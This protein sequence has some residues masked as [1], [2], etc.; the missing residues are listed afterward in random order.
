MVTSRDPEAAPHAEKPVLRRHSA[1]SPSDFA[2]V[3]SFFL[4]SRLYQRY[5]RIISDIASLPGAT[6]DD[7]FG[8]FVCQLWTMDPVLIG[9][10]ARWFGVREE[11]VARCRDRALEQWDA[12]EGVWDTDAHSQLI[13]T[14]EQVTPNPRAPVSNFTRMA[15]QCRYDI[16]VPAF[17]DGSG[18]VAAITAPHNVGAAHDVPRQTTALVGRIVERLE[19]L[20]LNELIAQ[21]VRGTLAAFYRQH[22][23]GRTS[24]NA[25]TDE[26]LVALEDAL[27]D[28]SNGDEGGIWSRPF[29]EWVRSIALRVMLARGQTGEGVES[30]QAILDRLRPHLLDVVVSGSVADIDLAVGRKG[31][32]G[33]SAGAAIRN[34]KARRALANAVR[35]IERRLFLPAGLKPV[36]SYG[37]QTLTTAARH[38]RLAAVRFLGR[39]YTTDSAVGDYLPKQEPRWVVKRGFRAIAALSP[40]AYS[41]AMNRFRH[42]LVRERNRVFIQEEL[43][44]R[45]KEDL[46]QPVRGPEVLLRFATSQYDYQ[47]LLAAAKTGRLEALRDPQRRAWVTT[48]EHVEAYRSGDRLAQSMDGC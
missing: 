28:G 18:Y 26:A 47:R 27:R 16:W 17:P 40:Y 46:D 31:A 35:R 23:P 6:L 36:A 42:L 13:D 12:W 3:V 19:D 21:N 24:V 37:D 8:L 22:V 2:E 1:T 20:R 4:P 15:R 9:D 30:P 7:T 43:W 11:D 33:T 5:A 38:D 25:L 41:V 34:R 29:T 48:R 32:I 10:A 39:W 45:L 44:W 14:Q